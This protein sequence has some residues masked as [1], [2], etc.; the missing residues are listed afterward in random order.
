MVTVRVMSGN[1]DVG[2]MAISLVPASGGIAKW[3]RWKPLPVAALEAMIASRSEQCAALQTPSA[4]SLVVLTTSGVG[5]SA[6]HA[7][8]SLVPTPARVA[9]I[10]ICVPGGS[11][12]VVICV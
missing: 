5:S 8:N 4:V 3:M 7:E 2:A 12:S 9:V 11:G 10:V 1:C 6:K